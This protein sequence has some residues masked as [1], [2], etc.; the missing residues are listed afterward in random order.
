MRPGDEFGPLVIR[1]EAE[2]LI[3]LIES[4]NSVVELTNLIGPSVAGL[5]ACL[6]V[7]NNA[8]QIRT[9]RLGRSQFMGLLDIPTEE[10]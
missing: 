2:R 8:V 3:D 4:A 7:V 1:S 10:A 9:E 5:T 6:D